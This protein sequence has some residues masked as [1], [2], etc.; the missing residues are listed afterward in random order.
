MG[1]SGSTYLPR[2]V[3]PKQLAEQLRQAEAEVEDA[4]FEGEVE[5]DLAALLG[6]YNDRAT[7]PFRAL[8]AELKSDL[9]DLLDGTVDTLFG[10]SVSKH[11]YVDGLSDVDALL[12]LDKTELSNRPPSDAKE[13]LARSLRDKYG[14]GEVHVGALAVT[15]RLGDYDVQLLPALRL[16]D[17]LRIPAAGQ[18]SWSRI[19]PE[20]FE[21]QLTEA[22]SRLR[23]RL[24][25]CIKLVKALVATLPEQRRITGYHAE[26]LAL[27]VFEQY[28]GPRTNKK[29]TEFF[30]ANS[31]HHIAT[32]IRDSSGQSHHVD[33]YLGPPDSPRRRLI[34]DAFARLHRRIRNA[35][36]SRSRGAWKELFP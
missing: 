18:D 6:E 30:F 4:T 33:D 19:N 21:R 3:S 28:E 22:N 24:V 36:G 9:G 15:V 14:A 11:T 1:G 26:S 34:A 23:G 29:M 12:I 31:P 20:R 2:S 16:K 32:R 8:L 25:P 35:N 7:E 5:Q 17:G 10:G 27:R 13:L